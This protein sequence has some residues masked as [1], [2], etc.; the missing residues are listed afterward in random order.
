M[1]AKLR[2]V[3]AAML[4]ANAPRL[5][6]FNE[7]LRLGRWG[8]TKLYQLISDKKI[9]AFKDGHATM[10]SADSVDTYQKQLPPFVGRSTRE[11]KRRR[12]RRQ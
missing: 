11:T 7:A 10:I 3:T 12:R 6:T 8:R 4:E 9:L 1:P 5:I 2:R